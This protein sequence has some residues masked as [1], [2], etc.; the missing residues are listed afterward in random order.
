MTETGRVYGE[1]LYSLAREENLTNSIQTELS[2][3]DTAFR[4]EPDFVRLLCMPNIPKD[5][6]CEILDRSFRGK[7]QPYVLNVLKLLTESG[8]MQHFSACC[9]AFREQYYEDHGILPVQAVTAVPMS[10]AMQER[11]IG[12]LSKLTGKKIQ[13]ECR[14]DPRVMGGIRLD[15]NGKRLDDTVRHRL[16]AIGGLLKDTV[17]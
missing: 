6:R 9:T 12:K 17:L 7:L 5:E 1:A 10:E 3:L 15:Y 16:E 8:N 4:Q 13:L 11:L 2:A 14:V